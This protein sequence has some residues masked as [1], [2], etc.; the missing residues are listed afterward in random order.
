MT[1]KLFILFISGF[2]GAMIGYYFFKR[3]KEEVKFYD[4]L[5]GYCDYLI[6]DINFRQQPISAL[7]EQYILKSSPKFKQILNVYLSYLNGGELKFGEK[8]EKKG[9]KEF[10]VSLGLSDAKTQTEELINYKAKFEGYK[11]DAEKA[12]NGL[13]KNSV[14]LGFLFG[15]IFG[16]LFI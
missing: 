3:S 5:I 10:F 11:K 12:F 14:K 16:L 7:T 1:D 13:G 15:L 8:E 2:A 4:D 6:G 9:I